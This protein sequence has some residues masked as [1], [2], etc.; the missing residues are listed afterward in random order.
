[1]M[2]AVHDAYTR[3][4][5]RLDAAAGNAMQAEHVRIDPRLDDVEQ[6]LAAGDAGNL[7]RNVAALAESL[8]G[9]MRHEENGALPLVETILGSEGWD[10][11]RR[12]IRKTESCGPTLRTCCGHPTPHHSPSRPKSLH[13]FPHGRAPLPAG[14]GAEVPAYLPVRRPCR[15]F[16]GTR[17]WHG[18]SEVR[19]LPLMPRRLQRTGIDRI[20]SW[21]AKENSPMASPHTMQRNGQANWILMTAIHDALRRDLDQLIHTTVI[22]TVARARWIVFRDQLQFHLAAE[23]TA[24]WRS[25]R[26]KVTGDP[27]GQALLDAMEDEH[28]LIG[29]LQAMADDAFAMDADA[30]WRHQLLTRLRTRLTSHLAHEEA[31]ALPLIGQI[32]SPRELSAIAKAIRGGAADGTVQWALAQA[33]PHV[34]TQVLDQLPAPARFLYRRVWLPRVTRNTPPL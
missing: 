8:T 10:A 15:R 29:P 5:R 34:R 33:S 9:P 26:A 17:L 21:P 20:P 24:M 3:D 2:Y 30:R 12:A 1:M 25:A 32:M 16:T 22:P 11:F 23:H 4:P 27:H 28:Q 31:D 18:E 13:C 14:V 19:L 7:S 6:A